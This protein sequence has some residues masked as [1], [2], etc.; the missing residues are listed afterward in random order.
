MNGLVFAK[1][2]AGVHEMQA[3][4]AQLH[5]RIRSLLILVDGKQCVADL[6]GKFSSP[7]RVPHDLDFLKARGFIRPVVSLA[8]PAPVGREVIEDPLSE[9]LTLAPAG[10][11]ER[12]T[13]VSALINETILDCFPKDPE[14]YLARLVRARHMK[15]FIQIAN[16]LITEFNRTGRVDQAI[17]FKQRLRALLA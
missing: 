12:F 2:E 8:T 17:A 9:Q 11:A 1:T 5:P 15:D 4:Q 10:R 6:C 7:D 16:L 3:R 14:P 13:A